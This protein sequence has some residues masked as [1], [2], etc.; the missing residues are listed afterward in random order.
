MYT[1]YT[2][3]YIWYIDQQS[4]IQI[5]GHI[6]DSHLPFQLRSVSCFVSLEDFFLPSST[7]VGTGAKKRRFRQNKNKKNAIQIVRWR[8]V[9]CSSC[10]E[11]CA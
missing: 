3:Y 8:H 7:G 2:I 4:K 5:Q 11:C 6:A 1:R 10:M 9:E